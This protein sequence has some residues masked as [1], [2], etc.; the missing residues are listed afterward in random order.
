MTGPTHRRMGSGGS[1]GAG[2]ATEEAGARAAEFSNAAPVQH[3]TSGSVHRPIMTASLS[4]S[5]R[6]GRR[7]RPI[8]P[9]LTA[10]LTRPVSPYR[11]AYQTV[12]LSQQRTAAGRGAAGRDSRMRHLAA[13]RTGAYLDRPESTKDKPA[14]RTRLMRQGHLL[15]GRLTP[16]PTSTSSCSTYSHCC[17]SCRTCEQMSNS[18]ILMLCAS[19][20]RISSRQLQIVSLQ[21]RDTACFDEIV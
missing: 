16:A 10:P 15:H 12:P 4:P 18:D 7:H 5:H 2:P 21:S 14:R 11:S 8:A 19:R 13:R 1:A 3:N 17:Q 20:R 6:T 9:P